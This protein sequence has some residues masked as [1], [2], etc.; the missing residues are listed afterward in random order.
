MLW[1]HMEGTEVELHLLTSVLY[2]GESLATRPGRSPTW[3]KP[4]STQ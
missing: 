4:F 2:E 1:R 3:E